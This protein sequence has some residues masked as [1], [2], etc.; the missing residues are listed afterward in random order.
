MQITMGSNDGAK[1][2]RALKADYLV[3]FRDILF[4]RF[5]DVFTL[6]FI[7]PGFKMKNLLILAHSIIFYPW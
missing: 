7:F 3:L 5:K 1:L 6:V 2:F 4:P